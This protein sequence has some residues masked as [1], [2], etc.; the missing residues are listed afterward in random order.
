MQEDCQGCSWKEWDVIKHFFKEP[1][2]CL[3]FLKAH[4]IIPRNVLCPKCGADCKYY[5]DNNI[6]R[7]PKIHKIPKKGKK[8]P[9]GY[10]V[11]AFN[12]TLLSGS[13]MKPWQ[14]V[15]FVNCFISH[16]AKGIQNTVMTNLGITSTTSVTWSSLCSKVLIHWANKTLGPIGGE[17]VIVEIDR[18]HF[19]KRKVGVWI[20][21]GIERKSKKVFLL[22]LSCKADETT[23]LGLIEKWIQPG[24][25]IISNEQAAYSKICQLPHRY[26]HFTVNRNV[27][28]VSPGITAPGEEK[29]HINTITR[30]WGTV[31]QMCKRPGNVENHVEQYLAR[32]KFTHHVPK[33]Q[34]FHTFFKMAADLHPHVSR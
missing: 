2:N 30:L 26:S 27:N 9:C 19:T 20:F 7:C 22:A 23:I 14:I 17:G 12:G 32:L 13:R 16:K 10:S 18:S 1:N 21:G 11:S 3:A 15:T 24:S 25:I 8:R 6:W 28:I 34:R 4:G 31:K 5:A 33:E 29:I